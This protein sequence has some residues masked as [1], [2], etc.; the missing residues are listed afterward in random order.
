MILASFWI[1]RQ[2]FMSSFKQD[3]KRGGESQFLECCKHI[4]DFHSYIMSVEY[5][6]NAK[7]PTGEEDPI[8][9]VGLFYK[10]IYAQYVV[11]YEELTANFIHA[12]NEKNY[13]VMALCG[14][15][16]IEVTA[17]LRYY[18]I[19]S[20]DAV[21]RALK[22]KGAAGDE[23][24][25]LEL[26]KKL[27]SLSDQHMKGSS[28]DWSEFFVSDRKT[29][30]KGLVEKERTR[31]RREKPKKNTFPKP[32]PI[33]RALDSWFDKDPEYVAF[34][35]NLLSDLVH[36]NL[37]SNLLM[38][39]VDKQQ[40]DIGPSSNKSVGK[41]LSQECVLYITPCLK[42]ASKQLANAILFASLGDPI[43][44]PK[45]KINFMH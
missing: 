24:I 39:G 29:F 7:W 2:I 35:Y 11:K 19:S 4:E 10:F 28:I 44:E 27:Y 32:L 41:K 13:L 38:M 8:S 14:R 6:K 9:F 30:I 21:A 1:M 16:L 45:T 25:N 22:K 23:P 42:E 26:M 36:P 5:S 33:G 12:I 43:N 34:I 20:H 18:N 31:L 3:F 17:T 15:A 40:L 37:G